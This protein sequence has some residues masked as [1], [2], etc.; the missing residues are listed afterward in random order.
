MSKFWFLV[1]I[2]CLASHALAEEVT[3]THQAQE[4]E[5]ATSTHYYFYRSDGEAGTRVRWIWN[6]GAQNEP[7]VTDYILDGSSITF[8]HSTGKRE[9][10]VELLQGKDVSLKLAKE[11]SINSS[12][13]A[14]MLVPPSP[15]VTLTKAQ[16]VDLAN[17]ISLLAKERKLFKRTK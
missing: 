17:L 7:E 10:L 13:D 1:P 14:H 3:W 15:D 5:D 12:D 9:D 16:R 6:G 11:Y 4:G 8:K 2:Y